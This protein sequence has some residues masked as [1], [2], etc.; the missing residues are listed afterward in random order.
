MSARADVVVVGAGQG[1]AQ[2]AM[3]LR[4]L[5]YAGSILVIGAEP[6]LPYE[7]PALSKEYL[8]DTKAFEKMLLRPA[9]FWREKDVAFV[10]GTRVTEVDAKAKEARTADGRTFGWGALVWAT[11]GRP[12]RL[13]VEGRDLRGIHYVRDRAD[14]DRVKS[15]LADVK[16]VVV[17]GAG[18]IGLEAAAVLRKKEKQVTVLEALDRV[19]ARVA[20]EA[21]SRFFEDQHRKHGVDLRL[22]AQVVAIEGRDGRVTGVKL[23][24]AEKIRADLVVVGIGITAE[25]DALVAAGAEAS[26]DG[27]IVDLHG[28]TSLPDVYAAGDCAAHANVFGPGGVV[29]LESIQNANDQA[30]VIAK[31]LAG[32]L[33]EGERYDAVPW[34][35]SNQYDLRLQTVGL[36]QGHDD[37]L[38]R[39]DIATRS[40]SVVYLRGGKVVA[41]DCVNKTKDYVQGKMLIASGRVVDRGK[42]ADP[43]ILLKDLAQGQSA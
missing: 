35:W 32:A 9:D 24:N 38:V 12:R 16:D 21:L 31:V 37:A 20:G 13:P 18:Y 14:V 17:I 30:T 36:S 41:L 10:L 3:A 34:F 40:F 11:G 15:E 42:L 26:A 7:R 39:G 2:T 6:E 23:A 8:A 28:R 1:G 22:G 43:E 19:L 33:G 29:R 25:V 27:V 4:Q 5:K